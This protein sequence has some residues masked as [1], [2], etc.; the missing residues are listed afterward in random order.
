MHKPQKSTLNGTRDFLKEP[1]SFSTDKQK[2]D[3]SKSS[4]SC[5]AA[6]DK[7][8]KPVKPRC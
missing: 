6:E 3:Y 1:D 8:L 4:P 7:S 2:T 5:C